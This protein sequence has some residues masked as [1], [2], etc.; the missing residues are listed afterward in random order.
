MDTSLTLPASLAG[1]VEEAIARAVGE[2]WASRIWA[3]DTGVW[4]T[5]AGG[6]RPDRTPPGLARRAHGLR[7]RGR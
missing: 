2:R 5:D 3:R 4:T 7:G 1:I 6:R